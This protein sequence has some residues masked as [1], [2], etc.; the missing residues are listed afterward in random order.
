MSINIIAKYMERSPSTISR[1]IKRGITIN[2]TY[3]AES[4][5]REI[6]KRKLNDKRKRKM[7]NPITFNYVLEKLKNKQSPHIIQNDIKRDLNINIGKDAIYEYIYRFH[8]DW[9]K[10]LT[11]KKKYKYRHKKDN[12]IKNMIIKNNI[13]ER[14]KEANLRLE[15]GH[16]EADTIFSCRGS[17]SALLVVVDRMTRKTKIKKLERKSAS[18]TSSS[19]VFA[20]KNEYNITQIHSI[21]YNNGIEFA[22]HITVNKKLRCSSYFCNA[23]YSWEKG[24]V[25]NINGLI[26]RFFPKGTNF[27]NVSDIE[28]QYVEDWINNRS[29][30]ILGWKSPNEM[31]NEVMLKSVAV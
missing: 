24:T 16:F 29:M 2:G 17:K 21:T 22:K 5:E 13:L 8:T 23:Y 9:M 11:R 6:R 4:T 31:Y 27:D 14:N 18:L 28:I 30:K 25:E 1:E 12:G 3:F 15:F 10:Y 20:L 26:R 7:N 19:I